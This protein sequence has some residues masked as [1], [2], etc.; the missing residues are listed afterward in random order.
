MRH[1][2]ARLAESRIRLAELTFPHHRVHVQRTRSAF[3][4][5]DNLLHFAKI[6]RD[7]RVDGYVAAYLPDEVTLLFLRKGELIASVAF[8]EAGRTVLPIAT[9]LKRIRQEMERGELIYADAP[10]EQL[11]WMYE[12]CAAPAVPRFVDPRQ[13]EQVFPALKHEGF[14][15][16]LELISNGRVNY[17]RFDQGEY[18]GGHLGL[19][20]E[21]RPVGEY[22][23]SLFKPDADGTLPSVSAATFAPRDAVP[24]QA[25]PALIQTYRELFWAI[26]Y[27]AERQVPGE[28]LKRAYAVRDLV[29]GVH[30]PIATLGT[31]LDRDAPDLVASPPELTYALSD[32]ALQL[33]EQ[34]EIV[35]PGIAT[36]ALQEATRDHRFVL[37]SAG[38]YDRLPWTVTW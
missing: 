22:V 26:A 5:L 13:P 18:R 1:S 37:Q 11:G 28:A 38:F 4:H 35:S 2:T 7:G 32:W 9:A 21:D 17:F 36:Q 20:D 33:F 6:D 25:P 34:L 19:R 16:V 27:A 31:P 10:M 24:E 15:G 23:Q 30:Q 3:I 8:T 12:S 29:A 14:S